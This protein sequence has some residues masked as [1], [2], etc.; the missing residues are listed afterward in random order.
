MEKLLEVLIAIGDEVA[1]LSVAELILRHWP[2]HSRALHVKNTIEA[3]EPIPFTPRGIDKLEPKHIRLKFPEK[4]KATDED[5]DGTSAT[6][7]LKHSI[8]VQLPE[9]SWIALVSELLEILRP[10]ATS[11]SE[12]GPGRYISGDVR[13]TIHLPQSASKLAGSLENKGLTHTPA[14][15]GIPFDNCNSVS[16]K[17]GIISEEQPQER[18]SSRLERLRSRKPGKEESDFLTNKDPAKVVRKFL[19]PVLVDGTG[20]INCKHNSNPSS[21]SAGAVSDSLNSESADVIEFIQNNSNNFGAYHMCHLLLEK[22]ARGNILY[23]DGIAKILDLEKVTRHWGKERSPEC[24][25][26]LSELYYDMGLQCFEA[27]P[28]CSSL[29]EASYHICKIIE[30]VALGFPLHITGSGDTD[31]PMTDVSEQQILMDNSSLLR[32]NH[33]FWIRFYWLS[34]RLSLLEGDKEKAQKEFSNVLVLFLDRDKINNPLGS[35]CLPHCKVIKKL[36]VDTVLHEMNLIKVNYLLKNSVGE[37]LEKSMHAEITNMLAPLLILAEDVHF[38]ELNDWDTEGKGNDSVELS[39]LDVLIKSCELAEP[40]DIDVCLNCHR[41]KLQI[42]LAGSP[43]ENTPGLNTISLSD[44]QSKESLRNHWIHL[45]ADEVK[46]I[47]HSASKIKS[48]ITQNENSV[49]IL[50]TC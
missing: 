6:K 28:M 11:G 44:N 21:H 27:S 15:P 8:E 37:M 22:I 42:L 24:S 47:S 48:I 31:S 20:T 9:V 26:F 32:S 19:M 34:A 2:S 30:S 43:P 49:R 7:K 18:R 33:C 1:C 50:K 10:L 38:G 14:G 13:L 3:S 25:L 35:I 4:R 36:T 46:A 12:P 41:R 39:A 23:Q 45:V 40:L 16:E 5:L 17:E 29:S